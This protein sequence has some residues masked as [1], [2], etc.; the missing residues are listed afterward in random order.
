MVLGGGVGDRGNTNIV[1]CL[2]NTMCNDEGMTEFSPP[3]YFEL[4]VMFLISFT[5]TTSND[6]LFLVY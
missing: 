5:Q 2:S 3:E 4:C 6:V 1:H